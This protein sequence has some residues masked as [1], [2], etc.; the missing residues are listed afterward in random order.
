LASS[1]AISESKAWF[2]S[3]FPHQLADQR[4]RFGIPSNAAARVDDTFSGKQRRQVLDVE[5]RPFVGSPG[6][7]AF[8]GNGLFSSIAGVER[9]PGRESLPFALDSYVPDSLGLFRAIYPLPLPV[10]LFEIAAR[11][12]QRIVFKRLAFGVANAPNRVVVERR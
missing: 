8:T 12:S 3:P 9:L 1:Q 5:L 2:Q 7:P 10:C 4:G 6:G 11:F